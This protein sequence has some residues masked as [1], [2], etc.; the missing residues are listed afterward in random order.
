M[1]NEIVPALEVRGQQRHK[2]QQLGI[3]VAR[4]IHE[5]IHKGQSQDSRFPGTHATGQVNDGGKDKQSQRLNNPSLLVE[6]MLA[7]CVEI[8][9]AARAQLY[10]AAVHFTRPDEGV[11][12][13]NAFH[14]QPLAV[15]RD[16]VGKGSPRIQ[17]ARL[18]QGECEQRKRRRGPSYRSV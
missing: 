12:H 11:D 14:C 6:T 7:P 8:F 5:A 16:V 2:D 10:G 4:G 18:E 9:P 1:G 13:G 17:T 15:G 3:V